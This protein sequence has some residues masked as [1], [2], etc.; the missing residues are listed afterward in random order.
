M[1]SYS[2]L[3]LKELLAKARRQGLQLV[4]FFLWTKVMMLKFPVEE[5][6][7]TISDTTLTLTRRRRA[8]LG[9]MNCS[10]NSLC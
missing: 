8:T 5:I 2:A 7:M 6:Q 4:N 9:A 10:P 3:L 1:V